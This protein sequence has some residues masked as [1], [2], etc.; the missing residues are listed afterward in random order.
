MDLGSADLVVGRGGGVKYHSLVGKLLD[1]LDGLR[2][3][4]LEGSTEDLEFDIIRQ[5][6][7]L[8]HFSIFSSF[9]PNFS[10]SSFSALPARPPSP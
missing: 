10:I 8:F 7:C 5:H 9:L 1:L 4:L 6:S 2:S 3:P